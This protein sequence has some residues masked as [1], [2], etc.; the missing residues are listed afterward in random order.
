M[1]ETI[2]KIVPYA[3]LAII[4]LVAGMAIGQ[5][6]FISLEE[7]QKQALISSCDRDKAK[8]ERD[9]AK[10][11]KNQQDDF[12]NRLKDYGR[13]NTELVEVNRE[14]ND[15]WQDA[16]DDL[17]ATMWSNFEDLNKAVYDFNVNCS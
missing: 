13:R 6:N 17:N 15:G 8:L 16:F 14:I 4:F 7:S 5:P 2:S 11:I 12:L 9:Y 10:E 1:D 3:V